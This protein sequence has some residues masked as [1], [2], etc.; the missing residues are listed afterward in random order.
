MFLEQ[1]FPLQPLLGEE[2]A[3]SRAFWERIMAVKSVVNQEL[4][5]CKKSGTLQAG[6]GGEALLHC[7]P[8]LRRDLEQLGEEL[9]FVLLVSAVRLETLGEEGDDPLKGLRVVLSP[10]P[11]PKCP[12]CWHHAEDLGGSAAHPELCGRCVRNLE[13]DGETRRVA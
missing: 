11:H 1:W 12:R 9:H 10:S 5:Q 13:G 2:G 8:S 6:L 4:E 3:W 7:T